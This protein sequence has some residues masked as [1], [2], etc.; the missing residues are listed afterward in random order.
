V[1]PQAVQL[2]QLIVKFR[3]VAEPINFLTQFLNVGQPFGL[4]PQ[5]QVEAAP[6]AEFVFCVCVTFSIS[7]LFLLQLIAITVISPITAN[8]VA[9]KMIVFFIFS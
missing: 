2:V 4:L 6:T 3:E 9:D 1:L 8:A 5:L 7:D